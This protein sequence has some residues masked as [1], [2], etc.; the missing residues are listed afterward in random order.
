MNVQV[1]D[2]C[3]L[4]TVNDIATTVHDIVGMIEEESICS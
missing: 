4:T 2:E 3:E 1:E